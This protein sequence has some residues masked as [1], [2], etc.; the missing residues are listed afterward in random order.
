[1]NKNE[2]NEVI[3]S[4]VALLDGNQNFYLADISGLSAAKTSLL[5]R[6]C[7]GSNIKL[8]VAKNTLIKKAL[9]RQNKD[10]GNLYDVLHGG[11]SILVAEDYKAPAKLIKEFRKTS[12]KPILKAAYVQET[13]FIGDNQLETL[14]KIKSKNELI[15]E[16]IGLLQSPAK[17][18]ISGLKGSAGNK[19]AGLVKAL[20]ERNA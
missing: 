11:T 20:Q 15:G 10:Y 9:E 16:V 2:K 4:I 19:I 12:D 14:V 1:M 17:N 3:D 7:F 6:Q 5:R 18:V 13:V 8:T